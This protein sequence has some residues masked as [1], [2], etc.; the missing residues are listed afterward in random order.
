MRKRIKISLLPQEVN[1]L[2]YYADCISARGVAP[3]WVNP[4]VYIT[5][6]LIYDATSRIASKSLKAGLGQ[7]ID[8]NLSDLEAIAIKYWVQAALDSGEADAPGAHISLITKI[9]QKL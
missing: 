2:F 8:A 6:R 3:H 1:L 4:T 5:T 7:V 9:D